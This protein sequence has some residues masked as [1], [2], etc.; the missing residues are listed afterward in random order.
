MSLKSPFNGG[1]DEACSAGEGGGG[2][3]GNARGSYPK[4]AP[5]G[6]EGSLYSV[7]AGER[8]AALAL[9]NG[10]GILHFH[11]RLLVLLEFFCRCLVL[12]AHA[13]HQHVHRAA[14]V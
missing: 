9:D 11:A 5:D 1:E 12:V 10:V 13:L 4:I 2:G 14:R 8:V 6:E 3:G 7:M